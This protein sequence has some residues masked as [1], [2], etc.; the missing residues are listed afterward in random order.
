MKKLNIIL[1]ILILN[2]FVYA[3]AQK[4]DY[5]LQTEAITT[6]DLRNPGI[7]W[8]IG[9]KIF[10]NGSKDISID[11]LTTDKK[12]YDYSTELSSIRGLYGNNLIVG[13]VEENNNNQDFVL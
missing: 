7:G 6:F 1:L 9:N 11:L 4:K 5:N 13:R 3:E 12:Y 10:I 8:E 2:T